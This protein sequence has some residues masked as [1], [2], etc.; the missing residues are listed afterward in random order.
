MVHSTNITFGHSPG[1]R[2]GS[3]VRQYLLLV[4]S[5]LILCTPDPFLLGSQ[6]SDV[7]GDYWYHSISGTARYM[8]HENTITVI[9]NYLWNALDCECLPNK[10]IVGT[11]WPYALGSFYTVHLFSRCSS[12]LVEGTLQQKACAPCL[13]YCKDRSLD[14]SRMYVF[15]QSICRFRNPLRW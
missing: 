5:R 15:L 12:T 10:R 8:S 13:S 1:H 14:W 7:S 11:V 9:N 2:H 3:L 6:A 4:T